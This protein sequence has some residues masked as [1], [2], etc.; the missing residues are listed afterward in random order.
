MYSNQAELRL[1]GDDDNDLFIVRAFALAA[2]CDTSADADD[3]CDFADIDLE[4]DP[5]TGNFPVD[6][7]ASG[8][9][10][11]AEN[12]NYDG[13]GWNPASFRKDNNGDGVCNK[14]D[15]HITG[16]KTFTT[17]A[18]PAQWEDDV[19]P[20]DEFGVARPI[21]GLGF[22][23]ARP[24]DIRAGGG[25]DEVSYNVNAPV[26]VDGGTGFDK[27]VILGTEFADDIVI[28]VKGIFGAGL[29][30]R[31]ENI[32]VVEVDGLEGDDEFFVIS[33]KYGTAYRI[34]GG[35][36]SDTINVAG[37]VVEDIVTRELEGVSGTIDHRL[38]S[39]LD[40]LYDGLPVDG[41][42]YN[43]ATPEIGVVIIDDEGPEGT[44]VREG[45]SGLGGV[46]DID[47]YSIRLASDPGTNV[48]VTISAARSP[49]EEA[50]DTF[51]NFEPTL[52]SNTLTDGPADTIWLCTGTA[53]T[54]N[55]ANDFKR[56]RVINGVL[57]DEA[58]RALVFTFTG[59]A[60]GSWK[61]RQWVYVYAVDDPPA[62][63]IGDF[64][65]ERSEGDRVVVVQHSTIS[66]N[67]LFD[68]VAVRN[69]EVSVRDNDTPGIYVTQI[70]PGSCDPL[71][72]ATDSEDK[73]TLVIE[74]GPFDNPDTIAIENTYTGRDDEFIVALQKDP[75]SAT[76]RVKLVLDADSQQAIELK[77][78]DFLNR[79]KTWTHNDADPAK[80]F[81]YYTI[82]F[83]STNWDIPV[84]VSVNARY[85]EEW[86]DPQTAVI[87]FVRDDDASNDLECFP[88]S[89]PIDVDTIDYST[90]DI[91]GAANATSDPDETYLFPNLRSGTGRF[92]IDVIDDDSADMVSIESGV[93]TLVQKCGNSDCTAP[94]PTG[95]W[96]SIRLTMR[97]TGDVDA[98]ILT[99][100]MVDVVA[101]DGVAITPAGYQVIGGKVPSRRFLG[102][103]SIS[104]DGMMLTRA[105]GSDLGS[106]VDE[107]FQRGEEIRV[108]VVGV[109]SFDVK[110]ADT[111]T[112]V[113]DLA[114][115]LATALPMNFRGHLTTNKSDTLSFLEQQ[116]YYEGQ[117]NFVDTS[118]ATVPGGWQIVRADGSS[119]L[120]RQLPRGPVDRG[121]RLQRHRR[122]HRHDGPLQ[123]RRHPRRERDEGREGRAPLLHRPRWR[124]PRRR[125]PRRVRPVGDGARA[126]H[127]ARWRTSPTRTGSRSSASTCAPTSPTSCR[128]SRQG[129]KWFPVNTHGLWKLQGPLAVEGGVTGADRSLNLGLK[130][131]GEK[132]GPLF[133]IGTQPPESKQTDVLNV[134]HDGSKE[135]GEGTMTSTTLS[136]FGMAKDLDF[137]PTYS[138]GN[139]QTFGEPAIFPGGISLGTVQFVDGKFDT[140]GAKSTIEVVN[141]LLGIG[142][143]ELDVQGTLDPD[144]PVKMTGTIII[145]P[146]GRGPRAS[147]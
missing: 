97:P 126:P 45:G 40:R 102:N 118:S 123:D 144:D 11:A 131:P 68:R 54:C 85:D 34:I 62:T 17:P 121:L 142:N 50:D 109:G 78:S 89:G 95:D 86:E 141:L 83:D 71:P 12:P 81:H 91:D 93:A 63:V 132:D 31:Y 76:I 58:N 146:P 140:N 103:L 82:D 35:L 21:I 38:M 74:G 8:T 23:T 56:F 9:C 139:P 66:A 61:D 129:V 127:R 67:P 52:T 115:V 37:D 30:V 53:L 5:D 98:A 128:S 47:R 80:R 60:L 29:N 57:V 104:S 64:I 44:S 134:F 13:D 119:W 6:T 4:A 28:S 94:D 108:S 3:D 51:D 10:D 92:A 135:D 27:V 101:I 24:L 48:Y 88:S 147:T 19:I 117:V 130:L 59:G 107:G 112:A 90:C 39:Q 32:E 49:Q 20:L 77:S 43:L 79:F 96:Y 69:V 84:L 145:S 16:A 25:E 124:L 120:G 18:D 14:A 22:S 46:P 7:N 100:G 114:I 110:I 106:F 99:D 125:R 143:D 137:G 87:S 133:K 136:G 122:L 113:S 138:S 116:G 65:D 70:T 1:E 111:A 36:G 75:G 41:L 105:N 15:A 42:D 26:S 73:R 33:T 72:C 2:V 55:D